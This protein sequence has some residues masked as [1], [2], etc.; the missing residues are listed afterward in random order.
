MYYKCQH[1][2]CK[3]CR[4]YIPVFFLY[5]DTWEWED[6]KG[7]WTE[8]SKPTV[9]L[10]EA[11]SLFGLTTVKLKEDKKDFIANLTK[12]VQTTKTGRGSKNIRRI[13]AGNAGNWSFL[14]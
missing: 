8:Y 11:A 14:R 5:L 13:K 1:K 2:I 12:K 6:A 7:N 9:C 3:A 10:L 4:Y